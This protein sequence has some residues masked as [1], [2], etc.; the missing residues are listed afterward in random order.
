MSL[1]EA[2][3]VC[4]ALNIYHEARGES[5]EGQ[6]AVAMV[7]LV[8]ADGRPGRLCRVVYAPG[9]FSWT[10]TVSHPAYVPRAYIQ[11]ARRAYLQFIA[12]APDPS[13]GATHYHTGPKPYWTR[14]AHYLVSVGNHHFYK[15][16]R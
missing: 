11:V 3:M 9:Q 6:L 10:A 5:N 1:F 14:G 4:L 7:T 12:N 2:G 15:D 8:R 16:V 13:R